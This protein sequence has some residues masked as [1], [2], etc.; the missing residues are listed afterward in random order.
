VNSITAFPE[1]I[2]GDGGILTVFALGADEQMGMHYHNLAEGITGK[3]L[4]V[5]PKQLRILLKDKGCRC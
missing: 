3:L 5:T 4:S 2:I 1:P